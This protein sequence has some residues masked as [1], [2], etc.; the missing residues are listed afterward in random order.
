MRRMVRVDP[1]GRLLSPPPSPLRRAGIHH[2]AILSGLPVCSS[3]TWNFRSSK[4]SLRSP[5]ERRLRTQVAVPSVI[6]VGRSNVRA[7]RMSMVPTARMP[8]ASSTRANLIHSASTR[9]NDRGRGGGGKTLK[10]A[11]AVVR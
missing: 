1:V 3:R 4:L 11:A 9:R 6:R 8:L 2:A 5:G 10:S 7:M